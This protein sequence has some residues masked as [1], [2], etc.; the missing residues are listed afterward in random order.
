MMHCVGFPAAQGQVFDPRRGT[1]AAL[2]V[3]TAAGAVRINRLELDGCRVAEA[4]QV[5][6]EVLHGSAFDAQA[7]VESASHF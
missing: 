2:K 3:L 7:P 4:S 5:L 6:G 1:G